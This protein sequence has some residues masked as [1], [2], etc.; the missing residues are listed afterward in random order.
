MRRDELQRER[1]IWESGWF[2]AVIITVVVLISIP[3]VR[4]W[5]VALCPPLASLLLRK[6]TSVGGLAMNRIQHG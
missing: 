4:V 6:E 3:A 1:K 2:W 5:L